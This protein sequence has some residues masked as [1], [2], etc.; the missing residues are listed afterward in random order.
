MVVL[1]LH[2]G[3]VTVKVCGVVQ[4]LNNTAALEI[5]FFYIYNFVICLFAQSVHVIFYICKV[6]NGTPIDFSYS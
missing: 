1:L 6:E 2:D 5:S 4:T 3:C